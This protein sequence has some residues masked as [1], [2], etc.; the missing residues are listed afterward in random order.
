MNLDGA[1]ISNP[2]RINDILAARRVGDQRSGSWEAGTSDMR[3]RI[4]TMN[5]DG[6]PSPLPLSRWWARGR[7]W[8][9]CLAVAERRRKG[10]ERG[11]SW[12]VSRWARRFALEM[13]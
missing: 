10:R 1:P 13:D 12:R 3:R 7:G 2:A 8:P 11:G 4:G 6:H 9:T 5:L